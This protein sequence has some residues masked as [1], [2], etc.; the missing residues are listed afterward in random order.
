[1]TNSEGVKRGNRFS[2]STIMLQREMNHTTENNPTWHNSSPLVP[3]KKHSLSH[4]IHK[5]A[6]HSTAN[7]FLKP[8]KY[9]QITTI[10]RITTDTFTYDRSPEI[11]YNSKYKLLI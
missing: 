9:I 8:V 7:S 6:L 10:K 4:Q 5:C 3:H 1:M 2:I 11:Y